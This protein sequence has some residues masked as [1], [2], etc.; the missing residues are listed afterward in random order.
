MKCKWISPKR[1]CVHTLLGLWLGLTFQRKC[2]TKN[3]IVAWYNYTYM[4]NDEAPQNSEKVWIQIYESV[5]GLESNSA[6]PLEKDFVQGQRRPNLSNGTKSTY[7]LCDCFLRRDLLLCIKKHVKIMCT[8][9][10]LHFLVDIWIWDLHYHAH[11]KSHHI[12]HK[13]PYMQSM[14]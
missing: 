9:K 10:C 7:H 3:T 14:Q 2:Y 1:V 11:L 12:S 4:V 6:H 8:Q 5:S 13:W